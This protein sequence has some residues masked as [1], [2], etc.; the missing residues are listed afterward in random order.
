MTEIIEKERGQQFKNLTSKEN[1]PLHGLKALVTGASRGIGKEI[2][3]ALA[4]AG[5]SVAINYR[6]SEDGAAEVAKK[7]EELGVSSWIYPADISDYDETIKMKDQIEKYF[8][9]IDILVNNAGVVH[10]DTLMETSEAT[11]NRVIDIIL[12]SICEVTVVE[13]LLFR[14]SS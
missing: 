12:K 13:S 5:A 9:K 7:I 14:L 6:S 10:R 4:E 3:L 1:L 11:W 2:A 8:G